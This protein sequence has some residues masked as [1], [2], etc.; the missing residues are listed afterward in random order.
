MF[1]VGDTVHITRAESARWTGTY[2]I[3]KVNPTTLIL[4]NETV[5]RLKAHQALVKA[6]ALNG[7]APATITEIPFPTERFLTGTV[8]TVS[9]VRG[10]DSEALWVVTGE[11]P[12]GYRIFPLGGSD[13]YYRG[14]P[15]ARLTKV[16][17]IDGWKA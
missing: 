3:D 17:E 10:V 14:I 1:K 7:A 2:K 4:S 6:G 8:V 5:P 9:G 15:A 13:R 16:T 12:K 11:S